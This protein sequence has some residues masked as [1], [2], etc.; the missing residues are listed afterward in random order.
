MP[1]R[2]TLYE[3]AAVRLPRTYRGPGLVDLQLNGYAGMDFNGDPGEWTD[4][5]FH[6]IREMLGRRGVVAAFP[7]LISSEPESMLA[8][9][10]RYAGI[11]GADR[12][13]ERCFPRLHIEG[14]FISPDEGPRGAHS[15]RHSLLP[16]AA[17]NLIDDLQEASGGRVGIVTLAP[18]LPGAI[19]LIRRCASSGIRA[20]IGHA[21]PAPA[22]VDAA[23]AAGAVMSTHLGNAS[24]QTLPRLANYIQYQLSV[25][26]LWAGFIADGHHMPL[27]TL[28]NF[29][30]AKTVAK[31]VLV[32]D[33]IMAAE[34]GPGRYQIADKVVEVT[35]EGRASQPGQPNLS[36]SV[37]TL[38][39][40]VVNVALHCGFPFEE[41]WAMASTNPALLTGLPAPMEVSVTVS[42]SGF[43]VA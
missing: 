33:A 26:S 31:S 32:T 24:H 27:S 38:D 16:A 3:A 34:L 30:R 37:L 2:S 41:A 29:L 20:S 8:R 11:V 7:T 12:A 18:E 19:D 43:Q 28:K 22:D 25:D 5:D 6:R 35:P 15:L 10:R 9:A 23:V 36:G 21:Q 17:P 13:L 1:A 14:P 42:A 4:A 39:R 40:A